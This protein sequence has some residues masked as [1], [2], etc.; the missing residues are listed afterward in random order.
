MAKQTTTQ[1]NRKQNISQLGTTKT[2]RKK[3]VRK[4][5]QVATTLLA[6]AVRKHASAARGLISAAIYRGCGR[7]T[8][9]PASPNTSPSPPPPCASRA[10]RAAVT[11]PLPGLRV[12]TV[13]VIAFSFSFFIVLFLVN[14]FF[15]RPLFCFLKRSSFLSRVFVCVWAFLSLAT[16]C[17]WSLVVFSTS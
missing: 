16:F 14:F 10:Q 9:L 8:S 1:I 4:W 12:S 17:I 13:R 11:T 2:R 3:K 5:K 15:G 7:G 6:L